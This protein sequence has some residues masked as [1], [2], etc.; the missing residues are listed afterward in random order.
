MS[1]PLVTVGIPVFNG[2][3]S[4]LAALKSISDQ[5][6]KNIEIIVSDNCSTDRTAFIVSNF[7]KENPDVKL[8]KQ[9][10]NLG[11]TK[12]FNFL[13]SQ[14]KGKY[15]MW[16]AHDDT[17]DPTYIAKCVSKL[18]ASDKYGLCAPRAK[19]KSNDGEKDT[20]QSRLPKDLEST[21]EVKRFKSAVREFPAVAMYGVYRTSQ[22]RK[23]GLLPNIVGS[24]LLFIQ[25]LVLGCAFVEIEENLFFYTE[26]EQWNTK[27]QDYRIFFGE[28]KPSK[29]YSPILLVT[30]YQFLLVINS[31]INNFA[32]LRLLLFLI[33]NFL[34][35]AAIKISIK[36]IRKI[37]PIAF[38]E[39]IVSKF[40]WFFMHPKSVECLDPENYAMRIINPRF[41]IQP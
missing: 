41:G 9:E 23:T 27:Q 16:A 38:R 3:K 13:A 33:R 12:N 28:K 32:K 35:Q 8:I 30:K 11:L 15:F 24:D 19:V 2:E 40:Y 17:R 31:K 37:R 20:W 36:L 25:D 6:Y 18:E 22:I 10:A 21:N 1:D 34:V 4:I 26:R 5:S 29:F 14:A 39:K 7:A